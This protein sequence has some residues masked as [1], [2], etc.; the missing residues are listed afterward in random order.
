MNFAVTGYNECTIMYILAA[1]SP[2]H[3]VDP[4]CFHEGYMRS[5]DI[6]S[7]EKRLWLRCRARP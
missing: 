7:N 1:S 3:P 5:G 4:V 2:T 6:V